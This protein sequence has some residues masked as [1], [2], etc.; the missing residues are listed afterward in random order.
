ME[1]KPQTDRG[2][3]A[4]QRLKGFRDLMP[5]TMLVRQ[6]VMDTLRSIFELHGFAPLETPAQEYLSTLE[7]KYGENERL[8]FKFE[9]QGKRQVGLRY[10]LTVPLARVVAMHLNDIAFPWKRYQMSPVWRGENPQFGRYREFYQC[11][12]DIVGTASMVADAE[13]LSIYGE[14]MDKLGFAGYEV[15]VNHRKLLMGLAESAGVEPGLT[16]MVIRAVDKLDKVGPDGV[17]EELVRNGLS[18]EVASRTLDLYLTGGEIHGFSDNYALLGELAGPLKGNEEAVRAIED[19]RQVLQNLESLD[20]SLDRYKINLSLA[21][22]LDYYT[23][24]VYEVHVKEPKI[25]ALGGGGRYDNLMSLFSGRDLPTCG[26]SF[27]IERMVDVIMELDMVETRPSRSQAL[28]TVFDNTR[29]S[30]SESLK[31]AG[32]LRRLGVACEVYLKPGDNM[33]K[34]VGYADR[35]GIPFALIVGP[36]ERASGKV[37]VKS[38]KQPPPNQQVLPR[39]EALRI[40][41]EHSK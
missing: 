16:A 36:D 21:R 15:S 27:G 28:V 19:L 26:G 38:L 18:P 6:H 20:V 41:V 10:D 22:G 12:I 31:L 25:G 3:I 33:G 29:E 14:A 30:I 4:P 1:E 34:Q 35:L 24:T 23:G 32:E 37:A 9:D 17:R 8:I 13:I 40:I 39:E 7:G 2:R 5:E 11:D